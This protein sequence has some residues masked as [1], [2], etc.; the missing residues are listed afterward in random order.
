MMQLSYARN[1]RASNAIA[2]T[3]AVR[4]LSARL[5]A[6]RL[7]V[8]ASSGNTS[9]KVDD[10]LWI[11]A[12]GKWLA[13]ATSPDFLIPVALGR[14]RACLDDETAI[15]ETEE[16]EGTCA[17][18][19]TAMHAALPHSV[20]VH[21]HSVNAIAWA[22]RADA[23]TALGELLDGFAWRWI[24][25]TLSGTQLASRVRDACRINPKTDVFL[26]GNHGLVVCGESCDVAERLLEEVEKRLH[27]EAR[28]AAELP[29]FAF[30]SE[31]DRE[32][33]GPPECSTIH[34]LAR[35]TLS[36]AIL[37]GGVLYPCQA[38]FLPSTVGAG[39]R[40]GVTQMAALREHSRNRP[41]PVLLDKD[42]VRCSA[43]MT[44]SQREMLFGLS[45][46]VRRI[47]KSTIVRYLSTSEVSEV[48]QGGGHY[49]A[50]A[51]A[52]CEPQKELSS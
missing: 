22:V 16:T 50:N 17:S 31:E 6:N 1:P 52:R 45:H 18:I 36:R 34:G 13:D 25:Y 29:E 39:E 7:L 26:L 44:Q 8:Q 24:P 14:A 19:E 40:S 48:L 35:D 47:Y 28:A 43:A 23:Q 46:V 37:R 3:K 4:D 9:V 32:G 11:K 2:E 38:L 33:W 30:S 41:T 21:V 51:N 20:V 5:A 42:R 10:T 12:S 27:L 49:L 15:P